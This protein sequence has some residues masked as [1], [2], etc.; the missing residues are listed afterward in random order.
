MR[1]GGAVYELFKG[2]EYIVDIGVNL[3]ILYIVGIM[4]SKLLNK[5]KM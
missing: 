4:L 3:V 5:K 2:K 1:N